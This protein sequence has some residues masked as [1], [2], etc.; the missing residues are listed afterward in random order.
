MT[1]IDDSIDVFPSYSP[2]LCTGVP[3]LVVDGD[4]LTVL[5]GSQIAS[6]EEH[7]PAHISERVANYMIRHADALRP[8][9]A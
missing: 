9:R 8:V 5:R 1:S 2:A 3:D 7:I 4:H 6:L